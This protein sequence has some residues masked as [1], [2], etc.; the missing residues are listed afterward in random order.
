M[1]APA[2]VDPAAHVVDPR[3]A[4]IFDTL[5]PT[6]QILTPRNGADDHP[7]V[8]RGTIPPWVTISLHSH[9]DPETWLPLSGELEALVETAEGFQWVSILPGDVFHVPAR[10]KHAFRNWSHDPAVAYVSTTNRL[11]RFLK[12]A[13]VPLGRR[14]PSAW[15]PP[16]DV[17]RRFADTA[18]RYGHWLASQHENAEVG[19]RLG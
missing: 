11:A 12:E 18:A 16:D 8:L 10:A 13:G 3:S 19:L 14:S 17:I 6:I 2:G 9:Q 4:Q 7:C 1:T 5:G 15:P